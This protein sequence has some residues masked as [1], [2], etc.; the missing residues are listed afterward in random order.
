MDIETETPDGTSDPD[1]ASSP[2]ETADAVKPVWIVTPFVRL[3]RV[4]GLSAAADA[5]IA[6]ALAGSLFFEIDPDAARWRVLLYLLFTIA[7]FALVG[8][9]IGPAID[10]AP[11]GRRAIV[12]GIAILRAVAACLMIPT[13]DSFLLFPVAFVNLVLGKSYAVAKASIVPATVKSNDELV[14]KNSR[15]AVL[16]AVAGF[17]GAVPAL[18][19]QWLLGT[20]AIL[21]LAMLTYLGAFVLAFQLERSPNAQGASAARGA[22]SSDEARSAGITLSASAMAILRGIVGF[23]F[24][25]IAFGFR[26]G[27]DGIDLSQTGAA[28]GVA[29]R[30]AL[31]FPIESGAV[32]AWQLGIV[33]AFNG[34][35][36]L[37]GSFLAPKLRERTT[38]ET[39]ILG[40]LLSIAAIG[41][42]ATWVGGLNGAAVLA[43]VVGF[44]ASASKVAFDA[45]VQ[46][47]APNSNYGASFARFETRFQIAWVLG[48]LISVLLVVWMPP[49]IGFL[50]IGAAAI[51]AA[52]SF[53]VGFRTLR[54]AHGVNVP[55]GVRRPDASPTGSTRPDRKDS[56]LEIPVW[57]GGQSS[58]PPPSPTAPPPAPPSESTPAAGSATQRPK[59]RS[60][61]DRKPATKD[62]EQPQLWDDHR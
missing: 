11:G 53:L 15:L 60:L 2:F 13:I 52:A 1:A 59:R 58:A 22:G 12:I 23:M 56:T 21:I 37:L 34:A 16:S 44:G 47:D 31:G 45:I 6:V 32:A 38:E 50:I 51:F 55:W 62:P 8:P 26:G 29:V 48:A 28:F 61:F 14:D 42:L 17:T 5:M 27:G 33:L 10:K 43:M 54:G 49:R 57:V 18:A 46:R 7:P 20:T 3:A 30:E 4:H 36:S 35:G 19:A 41:V 39:L 25:M 9:F 40:A 24:F